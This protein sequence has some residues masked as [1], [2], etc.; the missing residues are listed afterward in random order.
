M[1]T[2]QITS[3]NDCPFSKITREQWQ[4][5]SYYIECIHEDQ[6]SSEKY[7]KKIRYGNSI[8]FNCPLDKDEEDI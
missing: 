8:F 4:D 6:I 2:L 1:P 5:D 7:H 3:C